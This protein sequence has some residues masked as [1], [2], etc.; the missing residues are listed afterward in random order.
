MKQMAITSSLMKQW[1]EDINL[2]VPTSYPGMQLDTSALTG[3]LEW[4]TEFWKPYVQRISQQELQRL[5]VEVH[6]YSR[7]VESGLVLNQLVDGVLPVLTRKT[8]AVHDY[9]VS[10]TPLV[11]YVSLYEPEVRE[12]SRNELN[13]QSSPLR[14]A[15]V[16]W[17]GLAQEVA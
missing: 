14:H 7:G 17:R 13:R 12:L 9:E 1:Q 4:R 6:V 5:S 10:G 2:E 16:E 8:I 3:W 15:L 11:G